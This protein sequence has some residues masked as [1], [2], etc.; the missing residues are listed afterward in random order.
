MKTPLRIDTSRQ[1]ILD[2]EGKVICTSFDIDFKDAQEL[3][4]KVNAYDDLKN[5]LR[6][7]NELIQL[8]DKTFLVLEVMK[9]N[10]KNK[11]NITSIQS[12]LDEHYRIRRIHEDIIKIK[13]RHGY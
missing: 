10:I 7:S 8:N 2:C 3:I 9:S 4:K 12:L 11:T 5:L 6:K 1:A 13:H